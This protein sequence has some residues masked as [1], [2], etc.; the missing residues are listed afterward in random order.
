MIDVCRAC[1]GECC[2]GFTLNHIIDD[3]KYEPLGEHDVEYI[4][5]RFGDCFWYDKEKESWYCLLY[6]AETGKCK[7]YETRPSFCRTFYCEKYNDIMELI[8]TDFHEVI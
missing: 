7:S 6:D 5:E 2:E 8:V 3:D 4:Q 1:K